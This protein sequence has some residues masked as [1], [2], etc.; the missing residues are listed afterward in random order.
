MIHKVQGLTLP[1]I[2]VDMNCVCKFNSDQFYVAFIRVEML[3]DLSIKNYKQDA[4]KVSQKTVEME[5]LRSNRLSVAPIPIFPLLHNNKL[6]IGI[7]E[8][9]II[10]KR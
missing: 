4:I 6:N 8:Y 2:V 10:E 1:S 3:Q 5:H 9:P 7:V